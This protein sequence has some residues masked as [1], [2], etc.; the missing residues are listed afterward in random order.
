MSLLLF[1]IALT[2]VVTLY[3]VTLLYGENDRYG[4]PGF[5]FFL[6]VGSYF[7]S[8]ISRNTFLVLSGTTIAISL[9]LLVKTNGWW[10]EDTRVYSGT[11]E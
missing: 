1:F 7:F 2:P 6:D 4:Y 10:A 5:R 9:F 3:F 11:A 8:A